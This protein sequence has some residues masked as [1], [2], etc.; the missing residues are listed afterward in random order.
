MAKQY[1][2]KDVAYEYN[3]DLL[4]EDFNDTRNSIEK[5]VKQ[6]FENN[7]KEVIDFLVLKIKENISN[8]TNE[9][10]DLNNQIQNLSNGFLAKLTSEVLKAKIPLNQELEKITG[11]NFVEKTKNVSESARLLKNEFSD[12]ETTEEKIL[13]E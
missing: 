2:K 9:V 4:S 10:S 12:K 6:K 5:E 1:K 8:P 13:L 3:G 11:K 7:K